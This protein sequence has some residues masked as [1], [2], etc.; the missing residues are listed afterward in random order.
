MSRLRNNSGYSLLEMLIAISLVSILTLVVVNFFTTISRGYNYLQTESSAAVDLS[1]TMDRVAKV[2]RGATDVVDAQ[3]NSLTIYGY[4]L[5]NDAVV[6][7]I[8]YYVS[9]TDL[10]VS[11]IPPTGSGPNYTYDPANEKIYTISRSIPVGAP[12]VFTY[13]DD[14]GNQLTG[15]FATTQIKQVG[16]QI[17]TNPNPKVLRKSLSSQTTVT[18]RNKKTNL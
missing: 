13:Y 1:N 14:L 18:L 3:T 4:F 12:V 6:D 10:K 7:K 11:V 16:I 2:I 15:S 8:K 17:T 5:P 9:G